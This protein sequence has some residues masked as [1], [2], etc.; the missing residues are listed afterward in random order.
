MPNYC[1]MEPIVEVYGFS[2][3]S[4][5]AVAQLITAQHCG[6]MIS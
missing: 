4:T 1:G 5:I 6:E 3:A 2:N